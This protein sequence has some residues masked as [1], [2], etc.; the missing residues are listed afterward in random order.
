M[1]QDPLGISCGQSHKVPQFWSLL[2]TPYSDFFTPVVV[3]IRT[4]F[5]IVPRIDRKIVHF[6]YIFETNP[7]RD[8]CIQL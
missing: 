1:S 4:I 8:K 6:Y 7:S 2:Y 3:L 5:S